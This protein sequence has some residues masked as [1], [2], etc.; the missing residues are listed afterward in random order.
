MYLA[1][2]GSRLKAADLMYSQIATHFVPSELLPELT[3]RLE[4]LEAPPEQMS[5]SIEMALEEV[6]SMPPG[7]SALQQNRT[8]IDKHFGGASVEE[9]LASLD[10]DSGEWASKH[11]GMLRHM[12][13]T[14]LKITHRQVSIC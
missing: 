11:A 2:T 12:S 9:I 10:A 1:L 6:S 7:E 8:A 14:S 3:D 4:Q 13:P 5:Q